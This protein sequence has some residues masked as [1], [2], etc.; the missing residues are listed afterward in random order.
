MI[1]LTPLQLI[2]IL[3]GTLTVGALFGFFIA[4]ACVAAGRADDAAAAVGATLRGCPPGDT[5]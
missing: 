4:A 5:P 1:D 3:I 2:G